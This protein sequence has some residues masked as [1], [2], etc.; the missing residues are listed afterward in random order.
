MKTSSKK[1]AG[2]RFRLCAGH[3]ELRA[4]FNVM[5]LVYVVNDD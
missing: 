4:G 2:W 5:K 1:I 3:G